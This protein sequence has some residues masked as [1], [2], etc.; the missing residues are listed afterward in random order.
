MF[1]WINNIWLAIFMIIAM[2]WIVSKAAD[3]LGDV[4]HVLGIKLEI[5]TSVRGATFDAVSSSFPEFA[6]AMI[7]VLLYKRF[8]DVGVPTIAGSGIFNVLLIPMLSI[9]AF[10]G[11]N[12]IVK[13]DKKVVYR[14]MIFYMLA[15][16]ILIL[17]TYLGEYTA[18]T[19]LILLFVYVCYTVVLYRQTKK[20][21]KSITDIEIASEY[22]EMK[23]VLEEEEE[24]D[25]DIDMGYGSIVLWIAICIGFIWVSI[26]AIIQSAI[27]VS[28]TLK[29]PQYIVS[30]IIIAA[31]TSIPDT[32]LSVKSSRMGDAEGAVSNA[33][34]SNIF[35][36][37]ICLGLP[38]IIAGR[39]I[40]VSFGEN[41]GVL[42]FLVLSMITTAFLLLKKNGVSK[43][44]SLIMGFVYLL[45][46]AYVIATAFNIIG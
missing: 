30:V 9:I 27:V 25:I 12:L 24:E 46:L 35:D 6:T 8:A 1:E 13:V 32:L 22:N 23:D 43:R 28:D 38:M 40:P 36:I 11:K 33:V 2:S 31:A 10:K 29:I 42:A 5:P 15:I 4:L 34:G 20:Y 45:F 37:C 17:F 16:G 44:D 18:F 26:D 19:G 39:A 14:D 3:K 21:R 7:A 41:V